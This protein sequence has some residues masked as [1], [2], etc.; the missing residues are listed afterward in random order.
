M[1]CD[2][3]MTFIIFHDMFGA[4]LGIRL[5]TQ[6]KLLMSSAIASGLLVLGTGS[7]LR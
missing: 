6:L 7:I 5:P 4:R 1:K 2:I 3:K